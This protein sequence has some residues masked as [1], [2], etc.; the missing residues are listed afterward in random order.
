[1]EKAAARS[2]FGPFVE[3]GIAWIVLC[4][5]LAIHVGDEAANN[6]LSFYNPAVIELRERLPWLP[7]PVFE[8]VSWLKG[9][10]AALLVLLA[11]SPCAISR[12]SWIRP[13][14]IVFSVFMILNAM[15]HMVASLWLGQ[16]VPGTYSAPLLLA[17]A[18]MLLI[19]VTRHWKR[20]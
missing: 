5:A 12:A 2:R 19:A 6:F 13:L 4:L 20:V 3:P 1:M 9:L 11:L 8:T 14:A 16:V 7:L 17:A 15:G 10:A 18:I